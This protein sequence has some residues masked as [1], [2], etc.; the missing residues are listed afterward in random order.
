MDES[1]KKT[2]IERY[3]VRLKQ[4]G[5][6]IKTL[7]SGTE[8]RRELRFKIL[9]EI[10]FGD[11]D[12]IMDLGCGF[13]D[14]YQFL[15]ENNCNASYTG[16]D[17]NPELIKIAKAK[18][19]GVKFITA[20]IQNENLGQFDYIVST[21]AFNLKFKGQDNYEFAGEMLKRCY[22]FAKKGVAIDFM[23]SYVDFKGNSEEA[24]YYEPEKIFAI[25][26]TIT[27]RVCLRHDYPLFEFCLYLYPD[28]QGWNKK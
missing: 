9:K 12:S 14:F 24:F 28:F 10:G 15:M 25:A 17:I 5:E 20:D 18:Y 13:G 19:Q 22:A 3:N 11:N 16:V 4:F 23:S 6:S 27:K 2:I 1:D 7:A 8:E 21:S 26:K